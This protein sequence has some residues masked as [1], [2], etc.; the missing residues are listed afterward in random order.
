MRCNN[1]VGAKLPRN[2]FYS[3]A[4]S[5]LGQVANGAHYMLEIEK[6]NSEM[7]GA[8]YIHTIP[9]EEL[10]ESVERAQ[11]NAQLRNVVMCRAACSYCLAIVERLEGSYLRTFAVELIKTTCLDN[12]ICSRF[13]TGIFPVRGPSLP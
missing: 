12:K 13:K 5:F 2:N 8:A 11:R 4:L 10:I 3:V 7:G 1:R 6:R 9:L